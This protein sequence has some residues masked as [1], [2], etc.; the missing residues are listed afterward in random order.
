MNKLHL[1]VAALRIDSFSTAAAARE[2][3][4]AADFITQGAQ[5]CYDCTRFGCAPD[6]RI[7]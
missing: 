1:D 3:A 4:T 5:T 6:T 7:C 2:A